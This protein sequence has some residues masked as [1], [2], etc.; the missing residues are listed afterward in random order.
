MLSLIIC[1]RDKQALAAVSQ[2]A[3]ATVG[4]P[5]EIIAIDNSKGQHSICEAYNLGAA[6]AQ[7]ELLCFMHEDIRFHTVGWGRV[8]ADILSDSTIGVLGI[9]GGRRQVA[10]PAAWW[11]CGLPLCRENVL[12][13]FPDGHTEM[14]LHNPENQPL[15][16]VAVVDG[17][18]MCSR[19]EVWQQYPFDSRT[20]TGFHFYDVD[21]CSEIYL[22]GL[23]VCVTFELLVEHHSRGSVNISWL[24]NALKYEQKR[25]GQL[26]FG[27]AQVSAAQGRRLEV[28]AMQEF[29]G[30]LLQ[31]G[32]PPRLVWDYLRRC[33]ALD[34]VNRDTLWLLRQWVRKT[35][36][37]N[38]PTTLPPT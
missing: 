35:V 36:L 2:N 20:F 33:F 23:R 17:L 22:H 37:S 28:V 6:Q 18:W 27:P 21:Y 30:R 38:K 13:L 25:Q 16:D 24:H 19:R 15:I 4:V 9:T 11:G 34:P 3:A 29:I 10:T 8:V 7:Y 12:N 5:F 26:P 31:A 32:F 1:S 14:D